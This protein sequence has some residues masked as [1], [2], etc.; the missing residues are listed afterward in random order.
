MN[1]SIVDGYYLGCTLESLGKFFQTT[2]R[3]YRTR[4]SQDGSWV[5]T[6]YLSLTDDNSAHTAL[7]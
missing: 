2:L 6:F 7:I 3:T 1:E 5:G 4:F